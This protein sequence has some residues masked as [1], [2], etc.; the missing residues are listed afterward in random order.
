MHSII[1]KV[2]FHP[3]TSAA[4][5]RVGGGRWTRPSGK[6]GYDS[7]SSEG[8][9]EGS[10]VEML[11]PRPHLGQNHISTYSETEMHF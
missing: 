5:T 2:V 8:E 11:I 7:H 9:G 4:L 3:F 10:R 1:I 6:P